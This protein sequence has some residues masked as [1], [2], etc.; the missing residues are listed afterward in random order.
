MLL[1]IWGG[2]GQLCVGNHGEVEINLQRLGQG[3]YSVLPHPFLEQNTNNEMAGL[4]TTN[5]NENWKVVY[6]NAQIQ[7]LMPAFQN[8]E[9]VF[10]L[11]KTYPN[12]IDTK[13]SQ[14]N[15]T[16]RIEMND[17]QIWFLKPSYLIDNN[18]NL[19]SL[20]F[21]VINENNRWY[22]INQFGERQDFSLVY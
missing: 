5:T 16:M 11:T 22:F 12:I 9:E 18:H 4:V 1:N 19:K 6:P 15:G 2:M 7:R 8:Y 14:M 13:M 10:N 21:Q 17:K 20:V 3:I